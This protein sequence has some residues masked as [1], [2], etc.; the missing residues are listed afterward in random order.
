MVTAEMIYQKAQTLDTATLQELYDFLEFLAFRKNRVQQM[1]EYF[2]ATTLETPDQKPA[3]STR[4]LTLE[5]M[6]AA[7]EFEAGQQR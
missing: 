1:R 2:P 7:V 3:Y 5:E 6:N 4:T